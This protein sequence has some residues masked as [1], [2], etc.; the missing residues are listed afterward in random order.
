[1]ERWF[2]VGSVIA[3]FL[4]LGVAGWHFHESAQSATA[5]CASADAH[6]GGQHL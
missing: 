6:C 5:M 1:M 2:I 3:I 4:V